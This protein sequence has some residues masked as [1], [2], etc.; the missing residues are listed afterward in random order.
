MLFP[1]KRPEKSVV[2][3]DRPETSIKTLAEVFIEN[4]KKIFNYSGTARFI[5]P[6][7]KDYLTHNPNRRCPIID[8]ARKLLNYDPTVTLED[9]VNRFLKFTKLGDGR[10]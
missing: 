1:E 5:I 4:G 6:P 7:E 2:G 3:I 8:K 9:G 10:L